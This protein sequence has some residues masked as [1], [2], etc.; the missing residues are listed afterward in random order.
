M[1][2]LSIIIITLNEE[3]NLPR[4][5]KSIKKQKYKDYEIIVSDAGS[6]DRTK[7]I[8]I[9][10]GCKITKGGLPARG[11]NNGTRVAKGEY[12]LFLDADVLL[13]RNFLEKVMREMKDDKVDIATVHH[14]PM[15][16]NKLEK[17]YHKGYNLWQK[18]MEKIDPHAPGSCILIKKNLF[19]KLNGFDEKIKLAEDHA[20]AR[21]AF[22]AGA[23]Y[24]VLDAE[25]LISVRRMKKEGS[26]M[27]AVK[28]ILAALHRV[29]LGEIKNNLF[30]YKLKE[31][32]LL[33][34]KL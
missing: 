5:L 1:P 14:K 23:K 28:Y 21:K 19:N 22:R 33:R 15:T 4:L 32:G 3:K 17:F 31:E 12:I 20:L 26:G 13:P 11:R 34:S 7:E 2:E 30:R 8:A 18:A 25:I 6:K 10:A 27:I 9:K 29:T 24:K 16:K